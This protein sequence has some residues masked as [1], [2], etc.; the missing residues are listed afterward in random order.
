MLCSSELAWGKYPSNS[1]P[2]LLPR[3][4]RKVDLQP[5]PWISQQCTAGPDEEAG[6]G[7]L[8]LFPF[9]AQGSRSEP[10]STPYSEEQIVLPPD[11][12][13]VM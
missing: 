1:S 9:R 7:S 3:I 8:G 10:G 5:R 12:R 13:C 4:L 6:L 2:W 11:P